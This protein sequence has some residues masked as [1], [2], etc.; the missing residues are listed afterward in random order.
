MNYLSRLAGVGL[1]LLASTL[2]GDTIPFPKLD[3]P[4]I[5][6]WSTG[7]RD[8][9]YHFGAEFL[10]LPDGRFLAGSPEY[11]GCVHIYDRN[12]TRLLT[13]PHPLLTQDDVGFG[14]SI[15]MV[16]EAIL[17]GAYLFDTNGTLM[18]TYSNPA[19]AAISFFGH[20]VVNV[21]TGRVAISA[22]GMF[23]GEGVVYIFDTSGALLSKV[24]NPDFVAGDSG[25][26]H[27]LEPIGASEFFVGGS[28]DREAFI[29][30]LNGN[31]LSTFKDPVSQQAGE[32]D[33]FGHAA[34]RIEGNRLLVGA[35]GFMSSGASDPEGRVY[36]F[37]LDGTLLQAIDAPPGTDYTAMGRAIQ[38]LGGDG[39][40][41]GTQFFDNEHVAW[42]AA[43]VYAQNFGLPDVIERTNDFGGG[44]FG[45]ALGFSKN[46]RVLLGAPRFGGTLGR[47]YLFD[48]TL[49]T[50]DASEPDDSPRQARLSLT[51]TNI[52]HTFHRPGDEDWIKFYAVSN[53]LYQVLTENVAPSVDTAMD[54]YRENMNGDVVVVALNVNQAGL[55][56]T[57]AYYITQQPAGYYLVRVSA[58]GDSGS[59]SK[60]AQTL[61]AED[62][63]D[64]A[65]YE[66]SIDGPAGVLLT[67]IAVDLLS[68]GGLNS[69]V[70]A[71]V[72]IDGGASK[73]FGAGTTLSFVESVG[74]HTVVV[75]TASGYVGDEDPDFSDQI[76]NADNPLF[77]NPRHVT[78]L[79][80]QF[81]FAVYAYLP[82][83]TVGG[84]V[85]DAF[86]GGLVAGLPLA[87][88]ATTV[89][90][91]GLRFDS[92]PTGV[93]YASAWIT[94]AL[95]AF[96]VDVILP[97]GG[98]DAVLE[99]GG[100]DFVETIIENA[101]TGA[102]RG[103]YIDLGVIP[104]TPVD[105][106]SNGVADAWEEAFFEGPISGED[107]FDGDGLSD[108][109]E[110]FVGTDPTNAT[111]VFSFEPPA[112]PASNGFVNVCWPVSGGR[113]YS[114]DVSEVLPSTN[115]LSAFGPWVAPS[116]GTYCWSES[117]LVSASSRVFRVNV[118]LP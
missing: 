55:G 96:P 59:Q 81:T 30:D 85:V 5:L 118:L 79:S 7:L 11:V 111:S 57:E 42:G 48:Y 14:R 28:K 46:G 109:E 34:A 1:L 40:V 64:D 37:Q 15:A 104:V 80:D 10:G 92:L 115:W 6:D 21:G 82:V 20:E 84:S 110:Y 31:L 76:A 63:G 36:V 19:P 66:A 39:F 4:D 54:I 77:G 78:V 26:G 17:I 32:Y 53:T 69:P 27:V 65:M 60:A 47:A 29:F 71:T 91:S 72:S 49:T 86:T 108:A 9:C 106:N 90:F 116:N 41:I 52:T 24:R 88:D 56:G 105:L 99:P 73:A 67:V 113:T 100:G 3:T 94:D 75:T 12:A 18:L 112:M 23:G 114:V 58:V 16:G 35:P 22:P 62:F 102:S 101:I 50:P 98:W 70:G 8:D 117:N 103:D 33:M 93:P 68:P 87:F 2:L 107:D 83:V 89:P 43:L 95:G 44:S 51:G 74:V 25:F 38:P 13:I 97:L 61:L 45:A